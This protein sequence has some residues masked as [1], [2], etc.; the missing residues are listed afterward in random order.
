MA[1]VDVELRGSDT[2]NKECL[3]YFHLLRD[4]SLLTGF[5]ICAW[6]PH[7]Q[8]ILVKV[9]PMVSCIVDRRTVTVR[10]RAMAWKAEQKGLSQK[11]RNFDGETGQTT[12]QA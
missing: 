9:M 4:P 2:T 11:N 1:L 8:R 5:E 12:E 7:H 3:P 10:Y 6:T